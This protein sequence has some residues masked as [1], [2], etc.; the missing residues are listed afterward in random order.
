MIRLQSPIQALLQKDNAW[1]NFYNQYSES[2]RPAVF[3]NI[4]NMLSCG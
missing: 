3:D 2:I 4:V 1:W